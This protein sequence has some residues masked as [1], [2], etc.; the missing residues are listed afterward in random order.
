MVFD[1]GGVLLDWNPRH[2]YRKLFPGREAEMEAFLAEICTQAWN[3]RQDCGRPFADGVAELT[4]Q[5]P[6]KAD[7]ITAY[8]LRW[9]EMVPGAFEDTVA[10]LHALKARCCP[11]F[12]LTN[13]SAEKFRL[14]RKRFA[15]FDVFDGLAVSG[16]IGAIKPDVAIFDHLCDAFG[17]SPP[18]TVFID[19][20]QVNV[21]AAEGLGFQALHFRSAG[22]L[23][24]D[25][26]RLGLL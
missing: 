2:L 10:L 3:E 15:F 8:D 21:A 13:F 9:E 22:L 6:D 1:V 4:A 17:L 14:M 5:Y 26:K 19:D 24:T 20:T 25:L 11:V 23:A 7:L 18:E 16:E 12:A